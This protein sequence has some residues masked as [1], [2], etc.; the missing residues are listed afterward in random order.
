MTD[1][2]N[3]PAGRAP[4]REQCQAV[5]IHLIVPPLRPR[6]TVERLLHVN[7]EEDGA[8]EIDCHENVLLLVATDSVTKSTGRPISG[9][10]DQLGW[11][12]AKVPSKTRQPIPLRSEECALR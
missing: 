8:I 6:R 4:G 12:W 10:L 11:Q 2:D 9:K 7:G 1:V 5:C 3:W